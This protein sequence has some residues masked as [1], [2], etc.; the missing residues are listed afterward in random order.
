[1]QKPLLSIQDLSVEVDGKPILDRVSLDILPG[2]VH[3]LMGRNGSGKSTLSAA[4]MGHPAY[5]V[6]GGRILLDGDDVTHAAPEERARKGVFLA[7]Q[8]PPAIPGVE[9][10]SLLRQS[11]KSVRAGELGPREFRAFVQ[12]KMDALGIDRAFAKRYVNDGFSGGET[13]RLEVLQMALLQPRLAILDETD[14]GLDVEALQV[15]ARGIVELRSPERALLLITHYRRML[16]FVKPDRV[17]VL[18]KGRLV[19]SGGPELA[20]DVEARGYEWLQPAAAG[21]EEAP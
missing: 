13:K 10:H 2:E 21:A 15:V 5:H 1:M 18:M 17:H 11:L 4:L 6:T 3:A 7:F 12:E 9:V 8:Y 20:D 19:R 16:E 14:S